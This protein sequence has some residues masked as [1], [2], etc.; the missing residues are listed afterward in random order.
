[1]TQNTATTLPPRVPAHSSSFTVGTD[2]PASS[3]ALIASQIPI[4]AFRPPHHNFAGSSTNE[5]R[6]ASAQRTLPH[7]RRNLLAQRANG[8]CRARARGTG[9]GNRV[10]HAG[11]VDE[12]FSILPNTDFL[13]ICLPFAVSPQMFR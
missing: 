6:L 9:V 7:H 12:D 5:R 13:A 1:V 3:S 11:M 10:Q 2:I 8:R 4:T